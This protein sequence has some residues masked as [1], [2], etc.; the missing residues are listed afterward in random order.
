M[1]LQLTAACK[2]DTTGFGCSRKKK[3]SKSNSGNGIPI[4]EIPVMDTKKG[5]YMEVCPTAEN[6]EEDTMGFERSDKTSESKGEYNEILDQ[7]HL[8]TQQIVEMKQDDDIKVQWEVLAKVLD[9]VFFLL[10]AGGFVLLSL[11]VLLPVYIAK[12]NHEGHS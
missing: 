3:E 11:S 6:I 7:L 10:F 5:N 9:R 1:S 8:I 12:R 4:S 2:P